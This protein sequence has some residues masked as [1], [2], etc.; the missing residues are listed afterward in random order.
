MI[1]AL[2]NIDKG[3]VELYILDNGISVTWIK[4]F[5]FIHRESRTYKWNEIQDYV[6]Q[7]DQNFD[8]F[9]I[10]LFDK[11][12]I[13]FNLQETTEELNN[14]YVEFQNKINQFHSWTMT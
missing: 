3:E 12:K 10:R 13:K 8:L 1:K 14:F 2:K 7:P 9:K 5:H 6:F 4:Q 11:T